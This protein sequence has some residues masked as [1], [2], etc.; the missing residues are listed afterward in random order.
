MQIAAAIVAA[1]LLIVGGMGLLTTIFLF[2]R[3]TVF[4][5]SVIFC[6]VLLVATG[7]LFW[8]AFRKRPAP[9]MQI[10]AAIVACILLVP[11]GVELS[12]LFVKSTAPRADVISGLII[13]AA[14]GLLFW[15][16]LRKRSAP[17]DA[18][19]G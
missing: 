2:P 1:I 5:F 16:A 14:A 11:A 8:A 13:L 9:P 17:P 19:D 6:L 10:A 3:S 15:V 4:G 12:G 7:L 18:S